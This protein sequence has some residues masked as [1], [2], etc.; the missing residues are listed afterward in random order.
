MSEET[1]QTSEAAEAAPESTEVEEE[2]GRHDAHLAKAM[3]ERDAA[4]AELRRIKEAEAEAKS[5]AK[6]KA[7]AEAGKWQEVLESKDKTIATL[8]EQLSERDKRI[9]SFEAKDRE[10]QLMS[11]ILAEAKADK[12]DVEAHYLLLAKR[13][14]WDSAPEDVDSAFKERIKALKSAKPE[15]FEEQKKA[16]GV[17]AMLPPKTTTQPVGLDLNDHNSAVNKLLGV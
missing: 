1:N 3:R 6:E 11:K 10:S 9:G 2:K 5:K 8:K 16:S 12:S 17:S 13:E 7:A 4:K 15:L 14:G